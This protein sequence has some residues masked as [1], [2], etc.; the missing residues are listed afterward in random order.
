MAAERKSTRRIGNKWDL[1]TDI[2]D[3]TITLSRDEREWIRGLYGGEVLYVDQNI[4]RFLD[5]LKQTNQY[6]DSLILL[7]SDH[8]EELW[9]HGGFEHGRSLCN[10]VLHVPL[11][12]KLPQSSSKARI[13][14]IVQ[15]TSIMPTVLE[16]C[17]INYDRQHLS[18]SPL[19][20]L[21]KVDAGMFDEQPVVSSGLLFYE[22]RDSLFIKGMK[23]IKYRVTDRE[24]LYDLGKDHRQLYNVAS[25]NPAIVNEARTVM[26]QYHAEIERLR[27]FYRT[28]KAEEIQLSPEAIKSLKSLGYVK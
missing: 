5:V 18:A 25:E 13:D 11:F 28:E 17:G 23:Y 12:I 10:E 22:D 26:N 6:E 8:G 24:E 9:E 7:T 16:V 1:S 20:P 3:G 4:G 19:T 2:R 15:T 14:R 21:W 27:K